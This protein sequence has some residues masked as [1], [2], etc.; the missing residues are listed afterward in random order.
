M[1][2]NVL[3]EKYG[4][5]ISAGTE[6]FREGEPGERMYIIQSGTVRI[7]KEFDG[8]LHVL[9][10]LGKGEFFGEM[11]IVSRIE[12]TATVTAVTDTYLLAFDRQGFQSMIE[13]NAKIAMSVIDKLSR[14]LAE[15]NAQIQYFFRKNEES[16]VALDLYNRFISKRDGEPVLARDRV[17]KEIS[18]NLEIPSQTVQ[19][20]ID[21]LTDRGICTVKQNAIRLKNEGRL[22]ALAEKGGQDPERDPA[23][24]STAEPG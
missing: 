3:Y 7:S 6:I 19:S 21:G 13:K 8:K 22:G 15:A 4:Q 11:A 1:A 5:T 24:E 17:V 14:R 2:E 18:L 10:E 9:A 20:I 23:P 12:R 16:L